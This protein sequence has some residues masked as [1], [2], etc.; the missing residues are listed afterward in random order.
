MALGA[1][2]TLMNFGKQNEQ[3]A[4]NV[5][6][7]A[8]QRGQQ[9]DNAMAQLQSN[10]MDIATLH[11]NKVMSNAE[12]QA[13]R[14]KAEAE[15]AVNAAVHGVEGTTIA[16]VNAQ[17]AYNAAQ[18]TGNIEQH[19][20][21]QFDAALNT[22]ESAGYTLSSSIQPPFKSS[23]M[24]FIMQGLFQ[25]AAGLGGADALAGGQI[26]SFLTQAIKGD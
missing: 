18:A 22:T 19:F 6:K 12:V 14:R 5:Y 2:Q 4:N 21:N 20:D 10:Q 17:Q 26:T 11:S 23:A 9:A 8:I 24:K 16:Q 25:G 7:Q 3:M 15:E 1:A 13:N